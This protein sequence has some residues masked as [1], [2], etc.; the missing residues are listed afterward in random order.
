[1]FRILL[2]FFIS[3]LLLPLHRNVFISLVKCDARGLLS[4]LLSSFICILVLF[5][6][7][8]YFSSLDEF[9]VEILQNTC[10]Y[11]NLFIML[12][13]RSQRKCP[14]LPDLDKIRLKNKM[15]YVA[16][17]FLLIYFTIISDHMHC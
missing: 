12:K 3:L 13:E 7:F 6:K 17:I 2:F 4:D 9:F 15:K 1:M 8:C 11:A 5:G 10:V 16:F 14:M